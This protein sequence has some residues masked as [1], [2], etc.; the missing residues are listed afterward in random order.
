MADDTTPQE[1]NTTGGPAAPDPD[2]AP[3]DVPV[4]EVP[5]AEVPVASEGPLPDTMADP[6]LLVDE[7]ILDAEAE[8][9]HAPH[10][11]EIRHGA[12]GE[13][14]GAPILEVSD[15]TVDFRTDDGEVHA[16]RGVDFSVSAGEVLAVVGESGSGKSVTA[17]SLLKLLP[18]SAR[19]GGTVRWQGEDLLAASKERMQQVRG[20]EIA[21]IFQDPLTALNPV[22]RVGDQ[23]VEMI[24]VHEK[25]S[26][27]QAR[28]RAIEMLDLVGIPQA[29]KRVDQYTHEFSG[30]MRQRAMI[31][32]ALSC[33]PK[34]IIADEPTTALDVTV[35]AQVLEVLADLAHRLS[36]AVVLIT[37]DL[38]VV[39]GMADHI[40]VMYA[41]RVV[42]TG[43][44][45]DTF[46]STSHPYTAGLLASLPRLHGDIDQ[47]LV[48]IGGQP[49]SMLNP[50]AGCSFH[51][52]CLFAK[53]EAGCMSVMPELEV[54][55]G[56]QF[57]ACHRSEELLAAGNLVRR[58]EV[59]S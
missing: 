7:A 36:V 13:P 54:K 43:T 47:P 42:E 37:H 39:A 59:E 35:Q 41:G 38:G 3:A 31:A 1:P 4:R 8:G 52:R 25:M 58:V 21:M 55:P 12:T 11:G 27:K 26:K 44:V 46:D 19:V 10:I 45:D 28:A 48:P 40:A 18:P 5:I 50:P 30:G 56:G 29:N 15:L 22:Y 2:L 17:M 57:A 53:E 34:L 16:V 20:A 32:M 23:I 51:P 33:N 24:L 9:D 6:T 14:L 49:P